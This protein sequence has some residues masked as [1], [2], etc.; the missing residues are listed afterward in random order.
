VT[1][2]AGTSN[3]AT[4]IYAA[5]VVQGIVLV[6]FPAASTVFTDPARYDLSSSQYGLLF[7][8]QVITAISASLLGAELGSRLGI[9]RVYVTG[10]AAS[11]LSMVLLII[12]SAF[13]SDKGLAFG[14]LLVATGFLGAGFGLAVP[15]LNTF[16]AA[17]HPDAVDR[18]ILVLN[19]LLGLGTVLAPV[20][21]AVFLGVGFWLG[22]PVTSTVLLVA[23]LAISVRL[24]L[25]VAPAGPSAR[26]SAGIPAR[27][28]VYAGFAVLYGFCETV[29]GN[30]SQLDM[31]HDLGASTT[32]ASLALT[33]FWGMVT[34]GR[35]L[36]A[37]I[38]R[39]FPA[40]VTY[41]LLPFVLAGAFVLIA[42]LPSHQPALAV[43]A[44][45]LAGLGCSALL[46]L[47]ISFG[48]EEL[49]TFAAGVAGGVIAFYQL[50]YGIAAFG[51]GPVITGGVS[52]S[53]VYGVCA[54]VAVAMGA[55]SVVVARTRPS[56][57]TLHP[58]PSHALE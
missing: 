52:L 27:F 20:F 44:F 13:T 15:A 6:T 48:Q 22:L 43:V 53:T 32:V 8:P 23:L 34:A 54:G 3:E 17:F 19:A 10:L 11:L 18:S 51:I 16:A 33:A 29:N 26:S 37:S 45:G 25:K 41:H 5:G 35:V 39:W 36:F 31:T 50:G 58:R 46:P 28:W 55:W 30:W 57:A 1:G 4:V 49:T 7:L 14:L 21:V 38:Q 40:R 24:P 2:T 47:T 56:P 42:T 12:S 9:K